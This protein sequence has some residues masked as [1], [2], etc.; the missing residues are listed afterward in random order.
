MLIAVAH[1]KG[2]S[3]KTTLAINLA[4]EL[5]AQACYDLDLAKGGTTGLM[6]LDQLRQ[7]SGHNSLNVTAVLA[8][9]LTVSPVLGLRPSLA[10]LSEVA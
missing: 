4:V 10:G 6:F 5:N 9:I 3:S 1:Q 7:R 2:G 8:A